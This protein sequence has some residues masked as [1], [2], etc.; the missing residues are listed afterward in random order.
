[1]NQ[2]IMKTI[3]NIRFRIHVEELLDVTYVFQRGI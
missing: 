2:L 3:S 1:M